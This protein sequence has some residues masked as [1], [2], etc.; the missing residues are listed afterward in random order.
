MIEIVKSIDLSEFEFWGNAK[1][2]RSELTSADMDVI[3]DNLDAIIASIPEDIIGWNRCFKPYDETLVNDVF[4]YCQDY[5]VPVLGYNDYE[6]FLEEHS[7]D[8]LI[9]K[10]L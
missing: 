10:M 3:E 9:N 5:V 2:F 7:T 1:V 6:E 8:V 4:A